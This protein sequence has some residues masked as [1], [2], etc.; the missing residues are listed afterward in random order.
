MKA[1]GIDIGGT[2]I[3][4]AICQDTEVTQYR[5]ESSAKGSYEELLSALAAI[6][7]SYKAENSIGVVGVGIA[8]WLSKDR[9]LIL[10]SANLGFDQ[11]YL[12]R[13]LENLVGI[14]VTVSNDADAAIWAGYIFL[15]RPTGT[16]VGLTLGTDVGGGIIR[17]GELV[18][19]SHGLAGELGHITVTDNGLECVCGD[20]GC[21]STVASGTAI[22]QRARELARENPQDFPYLLSNPQISIEEIGSSDIVRSIKSPTE[23]LAILKPA[24]V[25]IARA[26]KILA[27][28]LDHDTLI[29]G[30]GVSE[31]GEPLLTLIRNEMEKNISMGPSKIVPQTYLASIGNKAGVLGAAD[32]ALTMLGEK[33]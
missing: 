20:T 12:R 1:L 7:S 13:D 15:G 14:P 23:A 24:A 11:K 3:A 31:L 22:V 9:E 29:I 21:L 8:A 2:K 33:L 25:A 30:G 4:F 6:I 17:N 16:I 28:V 26:S 10:R 32:L 27:R 5:Q 18:T 19:G